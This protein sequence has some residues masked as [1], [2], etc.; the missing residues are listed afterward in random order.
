ME[1]QIEKNGTVTTLTLDGRLTIEHAAELKL[2]LST[3]LFE[4]T[5]V[6]VCLDNVSAM[7][8]SSLQLF[9]GANRSFENKEKRLTPENGNSDV[10]ESALL[11]AGFSSRGE[12]P[13][14]F[15]EKCFWKGDI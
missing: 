15:C 2:I 4:S 3:V 8:L 1:H 12:C 5:Q 11:E 6:V 7:D 9:C 13:E 14:N 10:I